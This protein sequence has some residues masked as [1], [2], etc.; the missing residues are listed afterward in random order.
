MLLC[1]IFASFHYHCSLCAKVLK[2][3]KADDFL[4]CSYILA[5][6]IIVSLWL[7]CL[8]KQILSLLGPNCA[9]QSAILPGSCSLI[10]VV[11]VKRLPW[12][13]GGRVL[14]N[15]INVSD[16]WQTFLY[17][18]VCAFGFGN[19]PRVCE[20]HTRRILKEVTWEGSIVVLG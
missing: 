14:T 12:K 2:P 5:V 4:C 16:W 8:L 9:K 15:F 1:N 18:Y 20:I 10:L 17:L 11:K 13:P 7:S 19:K 6:L 3:L